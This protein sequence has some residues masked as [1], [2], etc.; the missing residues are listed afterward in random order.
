MSE[1]KK[2][3]GKPSLRVN[4]EREYEPYQVNGLLKAFN[5]IRASNP[6]IKIKVD[7]WL[8]KNQDM[9]AKVQLAHVEKQVGILESHANTIEFGGAKYIWWELI[10]PVEDE[11]VPK[12]LMKS[13]YGFVK[14][15]YEDEKIK[16]LES[17]PM[18]SQDNQPPMFAK[19]LPK[20]KP[21]D[22]D[23]YDFF[24]YKI[25][26]QNEE[27]EKQCDA[28]LTKAEEE[29][30]VQLSLYKIRA[31]ELDGVNIVW[32][33]VSDRSGKSMNDMNEFRTLL[34]D[35]AIVQ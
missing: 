30:K 4:A 1:S 28:E 8:Q 34:Y 32:Q 19:L 27:S 12:K 26:Y 5:K 31:E 15:V 3:Y 21:E 24:P 2:E 25:S 35:L 11:T 33:D 10:N 22:K 7:Y 23:K 29:G 14:P 16:E 17:V 13:I 20:E 18:F 6:Q 9:L